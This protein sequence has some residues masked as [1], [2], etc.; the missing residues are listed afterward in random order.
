[1]AVKTSNS[2]MVNIN[3]ASIYK[4]CQKKKYNVWVCM[5]PIG[6]CVINKF[7]QYDIVKKLRGKTWFSASDM[8]KM[9]IQK[10]EMYA[11]LEK[12][13]YIVNDKKR[14]VLS[15]TQGEMWTID[16]SKLASTYV[17]DTTKEQIG[18]ESVKK[19]YIK[20]TDYMD[21]HLLETVPAKGSNF[22]VH[23]PV[24]QQFEI[25]TAWGSLLHGN[26]R[27]VNHGLGDMIVCG[28]T[29]DGKPNLADRW[30][31]NGKIFGD[32]Y[33]NRGWQ[34][35]VESSMIDEN[36][37][38]TVPKPNFSL[39]DMKAKEMAKKYAE[40]EKK[41]DLNIKSDNTETIA[42]L[43]KETPK[44]KQTNILE[45]LAGYGKKEDP[46]KVE[47]IKNEPAPVKKDKE[48][49]EK[50]DTRTKYII[51]GKYT[52]G[53]RT[54][55]WH[56]TSTD[57]HRSGRYSKEQVAFLAGKGVIE[58]C[59]GLGIRGYEDDPED[60]VKVAKGIYFKGKDCDLTTLP[61]FD[62][63][64]KFRNTE[65]VG[66][67]R[68]DDT[69]ESVMKKVLLVGV[70]KKGKKVVTGYICKN[71]A[72]KTMFVPR[73]VVLTKAKE[74]LIGNARVQNY[75]GKV[76]LR[77]VDINL[78]ELPLMSEDGTIIQGEI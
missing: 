52:D 59:D 31:V 10:P 63:S 21:W 6:T 20:G 48:P 76:L 72:G 9:R 29:A 26:T 4:R 12:N 35:Y 32:T 8:M 64:G 73:D 74:G 50:K 62:M 53:A 68:K 60:G 54:L 41:V 70:C 23:V 49:V 24:A 38:K 27:G 22:A 57:E 5:P 19:K 43:S 77:G 39:I 18:N 14:F 66:H 47:P 34:K 2:T 78:T 7:E 36:G 51:K 16:A 15:G 45:S 58:N 46:K 30:I 17:F 67:I 42:E 61:V 69:V 44:K 55:G 3:D 1:M 65:S 11:F 56:L 37:V 13:A 28:V 25:Q 33:D 75:N 40:I 71:S